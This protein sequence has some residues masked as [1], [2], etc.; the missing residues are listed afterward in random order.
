MEIKSFTVIT[1]NK[2]NKS[3]K[4]KNSLVYF[5]AQILYTCVK[6]KKQYKP[7]SIYIYINYNVILK[8]RFQNFRKR[9]I[10][11]NILLFSENIVR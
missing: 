5:N 3:V 4:M 11:F 8:K 9:V 2:N 6:S 10:I 7:K 1:D